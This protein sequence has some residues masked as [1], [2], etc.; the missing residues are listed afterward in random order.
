MTA[1]PQIASTQA[2]TRTIVEKELRLRALMRDLDSVLVAY[3]GGV[4]SA[5]LAS[6]AFYE[7]GEKALAVMG[8]SPSVSQFEREEA[9]LTALALGVPF[10][11]VETFEME[12]KDYQANGADRCFHCKSELYETLSALARSR[13]FAAVV[14]GT[15]ADDLA[16]H[17]PGRIAAAEHGVI[18]PLADLGFT[19]E[20][21]RERCRELGLRTWDKPA[22]PCLSSRVA[23]GTPVTIERLDRVERGE[24]ILRAAG[25]REFRL[26]V[27]GD[28]ARIEIAEAEMTSP[29][30]FESLRALADKIEALGFRFVA[31]DLRGFRS[32]SLNSRAA[33]K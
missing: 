16:D 24:A 9:R 21:I 4:D 31:L 17:R 25:F 32:G 20:D 15:N 2:N 33:F 22:A 7:L 1:N 10:E 18:S 11:T 6:V 8:L 13:G 28:I 27:H 14:D 29:A 12:S 3:S 19:K 5:Y 30:A 26:R 23:N